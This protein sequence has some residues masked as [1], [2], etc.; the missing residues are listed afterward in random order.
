MKLSTLSQLPQTEDPDITGITADSRAVEPGYLFAALQGRH[1]DGWQFV[2]EAIR[3]GAVAVLGYTD[4]PEPA[5]PIIRA[6]EPRA[7]LSRIA[8]RF[9]GAIPAFMAG[10]TGT[11]GK[12]ST[13]SFA[14]Q[15]WQALGRQGG[16]LG[17]LGAQGLGTD[18]GLW[19]VPLAHTTPDPVTLHSALCVAAG[20]GCDH[21]AMEVSSHGL[22]QYRA[23][24]V[25]F[26]AAAFTNITQD[27]LDYHATFEAYF[28][29][30]KRLFTD[31]LKPGGTV[32]INRDGAGAEDLTALLSDRDCHLLTTGKTGETLKLLRVTPE[33]A[34]LTVDLQ[35]G[36]G[37]EQSFHLPLLGQF[38]AENALVAVGLVMASGV[39]VDEVLAHLGD[40]TGV[41]GR[42]AL[43]GRHGGAG[44]YVDYAHTPDAIAT[45][46]KAARPHTQGRLL[47]IIGAGGDRDPTKR[48][49][50]GAAAAAHADRVILADDNPR[51][52]DPAQIRAALREG[53]PQATDIGDREKA[54][55]YGIG[56]LRPGDV[57]MILGKGH[58]TGQ[59]IGDRT[60]SFDDTVVVQRL[61]ADNKGGGD[62]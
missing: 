41:P 2:D 34:G 43:A 8:A 38:Q 61:I 44:I 60:I 24:G 55:A 40:L 54:I 39:A 31:L 11:N 5:V 15:L 12:T 56:E 30:K 13:A 25:R 48:A 35:F 57:L 6:S 21:L 53:A 36:M 22:D 49:P 16:S 28:L 9:F 46:L 27:H 52:E 17:T 18:G 47:A 58:E 4:S 62:G 45:A 19:S 29:A 33:P 1:A 3:R 51:S 50:M 14:A 32:I 37:T 23:D 10:I 7:A 20:H 42:M 59:V 26:D